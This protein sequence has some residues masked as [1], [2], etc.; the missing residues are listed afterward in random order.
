VRR[1]VDRST[2][3]CHTHLELDP[4]TDARVSA[5]LDAAVAAARARQQDDD[6]NFD[7][8]KT[9][10]LVD[11]ITGARATDPRVPEVSVHIDYATLCHGLHEQSVCESGDGNPLPPDTVRRLCC[12]AQILPIVLGGDGVPLDLGREARLA[13]REQRRALR[14]MYRTCA[15]PGCTVRFGDCEI[16]HVI[17]W[18]PAGRTDLHNLLPLCSTHHHLVHEGGWRLA[19]HP[20]RTITLTRPD[21]TVQFTGSTVDVAP[22]GTA[23]AEAELVELARKRLHNLSPPARAPAA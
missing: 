3:M 23:T 22:T 6:V 17:R 21:G 16:H 11:L 19:L 15:H 18:H 9:D 10:A 2:G 12:E 13:S 4:E 14:A 8:L 5:A 7:H 20:D 1:W